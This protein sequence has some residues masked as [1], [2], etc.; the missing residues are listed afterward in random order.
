MNKYTVE[1]N[2]N[3]FDELYKSLDIEE[4]ELK[5]DEDNN[6]CLITNNI[7]TDKYIELICG[8]K[9]NYIP[10][11]HDLVNHKSKFNLMESSSSRLNLNEIRCPY[12]RN[13]EVRTLPY[14]EELGLKQI[15]GVNFY[16]PNIKQNSFT[17][18]NCCY[19]L[20]NNLFNSDNPE[21]SHNKKHIK[22]NAYNTSKIIIYNNK[23]PSEPITYGDEN[24]YC[25]N[26]LKIM[27]KEYKQKEQK[28][29]EEKK[30]KEKEEKLQ[31]KAAKELEKLQ[32]KEAKKLE[33]L[34]VK[35]AKTK[36]I[37]S[38]E[39]SENVIIEPSII[40]NQINGCVQILKF[41]Q[42]KGNMCGC[43]IFCPLENICKRHYLQ[44]HKELK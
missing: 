25:Y 35:E 41:G 17:N 37:S 18:E 2:I 13:K 21:S 26:H 23:N 11:Y 22:C 20:Q 6:K 29:K 38:N 15:N 30:Q 39:I 27:I 44:N 1:G 4:N 3:F 34:Q 12:C 14:Y 36:K 16:D 8:H 19:L 40:C 5:T 32:A 33:K 10:L 7:L 24:Y 28:E 9:F 31:A 42:N 43:K